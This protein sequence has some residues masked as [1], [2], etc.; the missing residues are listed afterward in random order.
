[1]FKFLVIAFVLFFVF[2]KV[3]KFALKYMVMST[4]QKQQSNYS[5]Q[6]EDRRP[7]GSIH[8]NPNPKSNSDNNNNKG[9]G[10]YIDYEIVK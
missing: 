8:I 3:I 9:G 7:E 6:R 5:N 1:M 4:I 2:G 10:E